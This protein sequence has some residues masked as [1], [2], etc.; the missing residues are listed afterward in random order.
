[1]KVSLPNGVAGAPADDAS[2]GP[3]ALAPL[4]CRHLR[5]LDALT[6]SVSRVILDFGRKCVGYSVGS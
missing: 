1:M 5:D 2:T 3:E 6:G 4:I